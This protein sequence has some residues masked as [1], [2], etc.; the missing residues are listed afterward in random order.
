[1]A[2]FFSLEDK[3]MTFVNLVF[4]IFRLP[5]RQEISL[6]SQPVSAERGAAPEVKVN[7]WEDPNFAPRQDKVNDLLSITWTGWRN[8]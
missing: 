3:E 1:M 2:D 7:A 4:K 6:T 5:T 8:V